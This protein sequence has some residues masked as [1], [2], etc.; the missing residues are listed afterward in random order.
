[1]TTKLF[2]NINLNRFDVS[3]MS[4]DVQLCDITVPFRRISWGDGNVWCYILACSLVIGHAKALSCDADK[5]PSWC[6]VPERDDVPLR[7]GYE[8]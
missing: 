5:V 2:V 8:M 7:N 6:R 4:S 3:V 1:M